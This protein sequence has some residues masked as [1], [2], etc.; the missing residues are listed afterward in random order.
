MFVQIDLSKCDICGKCIEAC[1]EN[2][3]IRNQEIITIDSSRCTLCK[4]CLDVC[5]LDAIV[6]VHPPA[7]K[8]P[9]TTLAVVKDE[10][11]SLQPHPVKNDYGLSAIM[12]R[13]IPCLLDGILG[14][15]DRKI[16]SGGTDN[17]G[18]HQRKKGHNR[19]KHHRR[20][21]K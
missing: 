19:N 1:P 20:G 17:A 21:Q 7:I 18:R 5:P 14:F 6:E 2:A 4:R 10:V 9:N 16:Q 12:K 3:I 15:L 8:E 11:T 13:L